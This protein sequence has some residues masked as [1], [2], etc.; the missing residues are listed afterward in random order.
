MSQSISLRDAERKVFHTAVNDGLWDIFLG[1]FFLMFAITPFLSERLGDFWSSVIFLPFW[2]LV[3]LAIRFVRKHVITPRLGSVKFGA[4]RNAILMRFNLVMLVVNLIA[5]VLGLIAASL[6]SRIPGQATS[7]ALGLVLLAAFSFA[8]Y[9]LGIGR[10]YIYALLLGLAPPIGEW[11][12]VN[13]LTSHHGYPVTFGVISGI[14]I[15]TGI[16]LLLRLLRSYQAAR[17]DFQAD[18]G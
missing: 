12:W 6:T 9:F 16:M 1:C 3:Y 18:G 10:L 15:L 5:L 4:S 13:H 8:A 14:M 17:D 2:G 7:I 11:L